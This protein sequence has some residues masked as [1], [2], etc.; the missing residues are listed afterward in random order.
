MTTNVNHE[1]EWLLQP[2]DESPQH[3]SELVLGQ[4]FIPPGD[5]HFNWLLLFQN[6]IVLTCSSVAAWGELGTVPGVEI[7]KPGKMKTS[8]QA[9][10][11]Q[12]KKEGRG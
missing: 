6:V 7:M 8:M 10:E 9:G 2:E 1:E 11:Q 4:G 5:H 3:R 12:Q